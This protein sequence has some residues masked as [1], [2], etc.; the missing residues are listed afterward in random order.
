MFCDNN[1]SEKRATTIT[2]RHFHF[3][4]D[5][6]TEAWFNSL[7][8]YWQWPGLLSLNNDR[9]WKNATICCLHTFDFLMTGAGKSDNCLSSHFHFH[10]WPE[11]EKKQ[12]PFCLHPFT[13][14]ELVFNQSQGL[15][16]IRLFPRAGIYKRARCWPAPLGLHLV[17]NLR[18]E[19]VLLLLS[20]FLLWSSSWQLRPNFLC[21][22]S[23]RWLKPYCNPLMKCFSDTDKP[24][25]EGSSPENLQSVIDCSGRLTPPAHSVND[26]DACPLAPVSLLG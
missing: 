13:F 1:W 19:L 17:I 6:T 22:L 11:L 15:T 16:G 4:N 25:K 5:Q 2:N 3:S 14:M 21:D 18:R 23:R 12:I 26:L 24:I 9:S 7:H 10:G 20:Y 8:S